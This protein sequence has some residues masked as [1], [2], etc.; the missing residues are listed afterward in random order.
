[1]LYERKSVAELAANL[2]ANPGFHQLRA[3]FAEGC[4]GLVAEFQDLERHTNTAVLHLLVKTFCETVE[5]LDRFVKMAMQPAT[6][7]LMC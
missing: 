1:M 5:P 6:V 3:D 4:E 7:S 2:K